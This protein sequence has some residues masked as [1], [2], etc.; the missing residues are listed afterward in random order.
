MA[1]RCC[2]TE[3]RSIPRTRVVT[4]SA[5]GVLLSRCVNAILIQKL[6]ELLVERMA[7]TTR[8]FALARLCRHREAS[9]N[10]RLPRRCLAGD[11]LGRLIAVVIEAQRNHALA[12]DVERAKG[13]D[14]GS[15]R[16]EA[17]QGVVR[18]L[19]DILRHAATPPSAGAPAGAVQCWPTRMPFRPD[20]AV[21]A[22]HACASV[23]ATGAT[24][25]MIA[26][27]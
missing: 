26:E 17:Q 4:M 12:A 20:A 22:S 1:R 24:N 18:T 16:V 3:A 15:G 8:S 27:R 19:A 6:I 7:I 25:C 2:R 14:A 5:C 13:G 23:P 11:G 9:L 21:S 10:P